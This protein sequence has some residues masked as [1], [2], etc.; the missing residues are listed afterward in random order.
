MPGVGPRAGERDLVGTEGALDLLPV[1]LL[2]P[3]PALG[4]PQHD[5]RPGGARGARIGLDGGDVVQDGVEG[6][7]ELLVHGGRLVADDEVRRVA[8]AAHQR[9]ELVVRDAGE[10]RRVGDLVAVEVQHGQHDAVAARVEE[11]VRVPA[12]GERAGLRLTVADDAQ[13]QQVRVV[14]HRAVGVHERVAELAALVDRARRLRRDVAGDAAREG[15]LPEQ[16]PHAV[17]VLAEAR[18]DLAVGALQVRVRDEPRP[19]VPGPGHVQRVEVPLPD[20]PVHVRVEEVETRGGAPVAQQPRL[21][22]LRAQRF[23]QQR[24]VQQVDLPDREVVRRPPVRV[25]LGQVVGSRRLGHPGA[26]RVA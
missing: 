11:L 15:E 14:E 23:A 20:R 9:R 7:G 24:V 22:V 5:H 16:R 8:V 10:H 17:D 25:E 13:R 6:G 26:P 4:R 18:V 1:D 21:D 3:R 19:A 2:R 12:R